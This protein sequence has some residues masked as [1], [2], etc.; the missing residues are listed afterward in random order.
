MGRPLAVLVVAPVEGVVALGVDRAVV[1]AQAELAGPADALAVHRVG[2]R[3]RVGIEAL[4]AETDDVG[5]DGE[6]HRLADLHVQVAAAAR[7]RNVD[8]DRLGAALCLA[9]AAHLAVVGV[10]RAPER[11]V[12]GRDVVVTRERAREVLVD[13][14]G[15]ALVEHTLHGEAGLREED[16]PRV[17]TG[18]IQ[19]GVVRQPARLVVSLGEREGGRGSQARE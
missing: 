15:A 1:A 19:I 18:G 10:P 7:A 6:H 9:R 4:R 3:E 16:P 8:L 13:D 12:L 5:V 14:P 11:G 2:R 17:V